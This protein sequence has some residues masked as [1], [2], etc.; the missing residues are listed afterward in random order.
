LPRTI[1]TSG[2][3]STGEK[4]CSPT[5]FVGSGNASAIEVIGSDD[6]FE[7]SSVSGPTMPATFV[8]VSRLSDRSSNTASITTSEPAS[9]DRSS[10]G[11]MRARWA[12]RFAVLECPRCTALSSN[13]WEYAFPRSADSNDTS[14][15]TTSRPTLAQA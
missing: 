4:K 12:S 14:T 9:F 8:N 15:S 5:K 11:R 3:R 10:V 7:A 6:V 13:F 2:I 1:S